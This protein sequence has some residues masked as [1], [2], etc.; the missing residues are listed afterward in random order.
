[1]LILFYILEFYQ[2]KDFRA[3]NIETGVNY[4]FFN[5]VTITT[6]ISLITIFYINSAEKIKQE[7]QALKEKEV[8]TIDTKFQYIIENAKN[9]IKPSGWLFIEHGYNQA[10][11][12]K[13]LF[14]KNGYQHIENAN[15][16]HGIHRV[17]FAQYSIV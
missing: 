9:H 2:F 5:I 17:T 13:D 4:E 10:I 12:L 16:I 11:I 15:D 7:L 8:R 14:E 6:F 3:E 1:M